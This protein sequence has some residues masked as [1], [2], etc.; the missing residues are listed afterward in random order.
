MT[1]AKIV[2]YPRIELIDGR[3]QV[4][5][6]VR[7]D[8]KPDGAWGFYRATL[9]KQEKQEPRR[10]NIAGRAKASLGRSPTTDELPGG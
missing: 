1:D 6:W 10:R 2:Q 8:L 5:V 3:L 7:D 9:E 4:S